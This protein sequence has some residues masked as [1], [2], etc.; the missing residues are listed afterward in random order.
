MA[1][2]LDGGLEA[3]LG[4]PNIS[5]D[6]LELDTVSIMS[7]RIAQERKGHQK[8]QNELSFLDAWI[9]PV[10]QPPEYLQ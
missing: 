7:V 6:L 4:N 3:A 5:E 2:E 9:L 1:C 8:P 10:V